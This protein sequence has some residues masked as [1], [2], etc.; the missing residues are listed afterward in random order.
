LADVPRLAE[1]DPGS[2]EAYLLRTRLA[3]QRNRIV[4]ALR[5]AIDLA[6]RA[7]HAR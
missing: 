6:K 1:L 7:T 5:S 4:F 2:D 3:R